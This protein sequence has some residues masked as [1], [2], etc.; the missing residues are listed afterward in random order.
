MVVRA[1]TKAL[2]V[3][4]SPQFWSPRI[5]PLKVLEEGLQVG[6]RHG[7]KILQYTVKFCLI[8]TFNQGI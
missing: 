8:C 5:V 7:K 4:E 1:Q 3:E 6:V 2:P